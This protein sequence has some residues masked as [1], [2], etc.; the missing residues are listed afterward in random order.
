MIPFHM[1][2]NH[3]CFELEVKRSRFIVES[4]PV[5]SKGEA[6]AWV[7]KIRND[8]PDARHHCWVYVVGNPHAPSAMSM[9]DDGEPQG[10][11]AK[12]MLNAIR[13]SGIGNICVVVVRYFGGTKL[14]AGG[15]IRAYGGAVSQALTQLVTKDVRPSAKMHLV[16]GYEFEQ[17]LR[18]WLKMEG[19]VLLGVRYEEQ[20]HYFINIEYDCV[21]LCRAFSA[22]EGVKIN[23]GE[24]G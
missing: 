23:E 24:E 13:F 18:H 22:A 20:V 15:L 5:E 2:T 12:P 1:S 14:G 21:D 10:T 8:Y 4:H 11:A 17:R 6:L 3:A 16:G 19:G 7:G 9:S